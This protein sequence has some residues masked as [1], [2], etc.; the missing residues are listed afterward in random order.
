MGACWRKFTLLLLCAVLALPIGSSQLSNWQ[1]ERREEAEWAGFQ[2]AVSE[3]RAYCIIPDTYCCCIVYGRCASSLSALQECVGY[4]CFTKD[5]HRCC[6]V[7]PCA[8]S[9]FIVGRHG[10]ATYL[11]NR[12][13]L[14]VRLSY[15]LN[16]TIMAGE[17]HVHTAAAQVCACTKCLRYTV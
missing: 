1:C 5:R 4:V 17:S 16:S 2:T 12:H 14:I 11:S 9:A 8:F 7:P 6:Y 10:W 15:L 3:C 13:R